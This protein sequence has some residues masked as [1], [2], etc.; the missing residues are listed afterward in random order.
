MNDLRNLT[1]LMQQIGAAKKKA[2][3]L[4]Q[5]ELAVLIREQEKVLQKQIKQLVKSAKK[6]LNSFYSHYNE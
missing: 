2:I 3:E 1:I 4:E 5:F 6:V